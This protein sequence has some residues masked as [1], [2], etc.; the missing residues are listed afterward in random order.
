[1]S[2]KYAAVFVTA[3]FLCAVAVPVH[4]LLNKLRRANG[5]TAA[6]PTSELEQCS[7]NLDIANQSFANDWA[8]AR[9]PELFAEPK[10]SVEGMHLPK[11]YERDLLVR[12]WAEAQLAAYDKE[13]AWHTIQLHRTI[14]ERQFEEAI[15]SAKNAH[16]RLKNDPSDALAKDELRASLS[17]AFL[18]RLEL[19]A[20]AVLESHLDTKV[21]L[22]KAVEEYTTADCGEEARLLILARLIETD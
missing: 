12:A 2:R 10:D 17:Q 14:T 22:S 4:L 9:V 16:G 18:R 15:A 5:D 6:T 11:T 8:E 19:H 7:L 20:P 1:M 21:S 13:R 3:L